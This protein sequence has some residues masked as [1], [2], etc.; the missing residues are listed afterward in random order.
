MDKSID[1]LATY[2]QDL[3][4]GDLSP[5]AIRAVKHRFIDSI[6]CAIGGYLSEPSKLARRLCRPVGSNFNARVIGSLVR[7]DPEMAA[8]ANSIMVRYLDFSDSY[9]MKGVGHPSDTIGAVLAVAESTHADGKKLI[10]ATALAYEMQVLFIEKI[11]VKEEFDGCALGA[12]FGSTM[13]AGKI[14]N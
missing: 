12:T 2:C 11:P 13:G 10:S 5:G 8:F 4:F 7:T 14:L 1:F 9:R 3:S 6:G